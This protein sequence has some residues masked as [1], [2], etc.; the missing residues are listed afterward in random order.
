L[1]TQHRQHN[2][3]DKCIGLMLAVVV[4]IMP[5]IVRVA[6]RPFSPELKL[7]FG[8]DYYVDTFSYWKSWFVIVP[9]VIIIFSNVGSLMVQRRIPNLK[10]FFTNTPIVISLVFLVLMIVSTLHS[11]YTYTSWLGANHR[12]EGA[13]MW[14]SYFTVFFATMNFVKGADDAKLILYSLFFSSTIIGVIGVGQT[15]G[16]NFF[17][18]E[19]AKLLITTGTPATGI[20]SAFRYA[21]STMLHHNTFG[22]YSAMLTLVLLFTGLAFYKKRTVMLLFMLVGG[23][24]LICVFGSRAFGG[25]VGLIGACVIPAF[26]YVC[27]LL[28]K[29]QKAME[30]RHIFIKRLTFVLIFIIVIF[31]VLVLF[32]IIGL[33]TGNNNDHSQLTESS[34]DVPVWGFSGR[35]DWGTQRGYIWA[36]SFPLFPAHIFIGSGP[37]TF[38]SM[39]PQHDR[40]GKK[41]F[42]NNPNIVMDLTQNL[43]IRTWITTGGLSALALFALFVHYLMSTF[44]SLVKAENEPA[45]SYRLRLGLFAGIIAFCI[46]SMATDSTVGS[47]GVFFVLLG[48][49]YG[50]NI[51]ARKFI[52]LS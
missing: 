44:W 2:I 37:D 31:L 18:S 50:L 28:Y 39:F 52:K 16:W 21:N 11:P 48:M 22:K 10:Y 33:P 19:I 25:L 49:G 7:L 42:F 23:L 15:I 8:G 43:F 20:S 41:R 13:L 46:S 4:G 17:N 36:R 30:A 47:T 40:M 29:K 1:D 26:T 27:S 34:A 35:E 5:L 32:V 51:F 3:A 45:F 38:A 9:A 6:I 12:S 24:M 14:F